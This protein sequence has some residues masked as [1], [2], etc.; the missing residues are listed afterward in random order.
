MKYNPIAE[1]F[2]SFARKKISLS[3]ISPA[4]GED[5]DKTIPT[6]FR[7]PADIKNYYEQMAAHSRM[8]LQAIIVQALGGVM[9]SHINN[10]ANSDIR[11]L[12]NRVYSIFAMHGVPIY[13][14]PKILKEFNVTSETLSDD[15]SLVDCLSEKMLDFLCNTFNLEKQWIL[16]GAGS[17]HQSFHVY[18]DL[19]KWLVI[20]QRTSA[21]ITLKIFFDVRIL[22]NPV[23]DW[24]QGAGNNST[25]DV[26][27]A[28]VVEQE[29]N[30]VKY[31][32]LYV[33]E[34]LNWDYHKTNNHIYGLIEGMQI[35][36]KYGD[37][38]IQKFSS[39]IPSN[40]FIH[41]NFALPA[42][43][44]FSGINSSIK[45]EENSTMNTRGAVDDFA[46]VNKALDEV[47]NK[48]KDYL[49]EHGNENHD[50]HSIE[51]ELEK[52]RNDEFKDFPDKIYFIKI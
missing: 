8:S 20:M 2:N 26:R 42:L 12:A 47:K 9:E 4:L 27:C 23:I 11:S 41:N 13:D 17:S 33:L 15:S 25:R 34:S 46:T 28:L 37:R 49:Q 51:R 6:A 45:F 10:Q 44:N 40:Y 38:K 39:H 21:P 3:D 31:N 1:L 48:E 16:N 52:L 30:G 5:K 43:N 36:R 35:T 24:D 19:S 50:Y 14:I 29:M 32:K 22:E 7:L 18:K